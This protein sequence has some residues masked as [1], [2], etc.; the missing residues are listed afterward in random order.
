[1]DLNFIQ[2]LDETGERTDSSDNTMN[3]VALRTT[4][5]NITF[6]PFGDNRLNT[7]FSQWTVLKN[8]DSVEHQK[9]LNMLNTCEWDKK[10]DYINDEFVKI[11]KYTPEEKAKILS[12]RE[13]EESKRF[14][15]AERQLAIAI[16]DDYKLGL[17]SATPEELLD[18]QDYIRAIQPVDS[19]SRVAKLIKPVRPEIFK[20][21]DE[22]RKDGVI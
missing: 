4:E 19:T 18:V 8:V 12:E 13:L 2:G 14:Y 22:K 11:E 5:G 16:M 9:I 17:V 20:V 1:M 6:T 21:Y 3:Y 7:V 15:L 10:V